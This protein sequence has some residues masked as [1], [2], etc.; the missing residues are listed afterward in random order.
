MNKFLLL[1]DEQFWDDADFLAYSAERRDLF[2]WFVNVDRVAPGTAALMTFAFADEAL[3]TETLT[4]EE[5]VALV[6]VHLR[7]MYGAQVPSPRAM[8]RSRWCTDEW[9]RGAYS[10]TSTTTDMSHFDAL[11]AP[12]GRVHFAGEHTD[13]ANFST[14]H[15]A[16]LSGRRA[17]REILGA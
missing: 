4:D 9:T 17:A 13:R 6:M 2:N 12:A 5:V 16:Y 14:V 8:R 10:F 7:D 11:A 3:R 15:G 1:W